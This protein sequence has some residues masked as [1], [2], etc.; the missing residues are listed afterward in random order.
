MDHPAC[1]LAM[2]AAQHGPHTDMLHTAKTH[3]IITAKDFIELFAE[4]FDDCDATQTV[5]FK[6]RAVYGDV[7]TCID[8]DNH[9]ELLYQFT[10]FGDEKVTNM[11]AN[12][13]SFITP[14][15][16]LISAK[17]PEVW[18]KLMQ[19]P[20][21]TKSA[22]NED[23]GEPEPNLIQQ[24]DIEGKWDECDED[25]RNIIWD[26]VEK[27]MSY[28]MMWTTYSRI[29]PNMMNTMMK[30]AKEKITE[31]A[32]A[33]V[34]MSNESIQSS[35]MESIPEMLKHVS[36]AELLQL[37]QNIINNPSMLADIQGM[38]STVQ[39]VTP[40]FDFGSVCSTMMVAAKA[41]SGG[42]GGQGGQSETPSP[43]T[44]TIGEEVTSSSNMSDAVNAINANMTDE[45]RRRAREMAAAMIRGS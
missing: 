35:V 40:G 9:T 19:H 20:A 28:G 44:A 16:A 4:Y 31:K 11:L 36:T 8:E 39:G 17:N 3:F 25:A 38:G 1:K 33:G 13:G 7:P 29:P 23:T 18:S 2:S 12:F 15:K 27:L 5:L 22:T 42:Q 24:L 30:C 14:Y 34:R 21:A 45:H 37:G 41:I 26:A 10:P 32:S 43:D 6:F